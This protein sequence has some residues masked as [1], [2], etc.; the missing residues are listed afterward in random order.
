MLTWPQ[1]YFRELYLAPQN[2][3]KS[4]YFR[5]GENSQATLFLV[6]RF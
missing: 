2:L 6:R 1:P 5:T 4:L 3:R